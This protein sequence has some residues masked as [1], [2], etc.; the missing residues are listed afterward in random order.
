[1]ETWLFTAGTATMML[2]S[3]LD[4]RQTACPGEVVTYTCTVPRTS[5]AGWDV[6]P[7]IMQ[8]TYFPSSQTERPE[9]IGDFQVVLTNVGP[10]DMGLADLTFTLTVT[11][12]LGRNGT[13]VQ[14]LGDEAGERISLVL[15]VASELSMIFSVDLP[16]SEG[17]SSNKNLEYGLRFYTCTVF[18]CLWCVL[19]GTYCLVLSP[20]QMFLVYPATFSKNR[21]WTPSL[22]KLGPN[23]NVYWYVVTPIRSLN[24]IMTDSQ[25]V[26]FLDAKAYITSN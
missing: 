10:I 9:D 24:Y 1:M 6:P 13:V 25:L 21:V 15:K 4:G 14:C 5:S 8:L 23:Y 2:T 19:T 3:T 11:A 16:H 26:D 18:V 7:D 12:T 20:H 22:G 17:V